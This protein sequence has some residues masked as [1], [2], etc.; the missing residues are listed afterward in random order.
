MSAQK[1]QKQQT[2]PV[3]RTPVLPLKATAHTSGAVGH[4][5]IPP[6]VPADQSSFPFPPAESN[7]NADIANMIR[8]MDARL[9]DK[10]DYV[11]VSYTHLTLPTIYS[12]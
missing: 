4:S 5:P 8:L 9:G 11:T 10:M 7:T 1:A 6:I 2:A 3:L 12:V